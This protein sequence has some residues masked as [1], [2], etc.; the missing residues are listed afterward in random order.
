MEQE[1]KQ[2]FERGDKENVKALCNSIFKQLIP[3]LVKETF[4]NLKFL[5]F[6]RS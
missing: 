2:A 3:N 6:F 1:S 5:Y 4:K